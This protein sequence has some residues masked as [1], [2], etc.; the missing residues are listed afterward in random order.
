MISE[1]ALFLILPVN[2]GISYPVDDATLDPMSYHLY[3]GHGLC[4]PW[5]GATDGKTGVMALVETPNDAAVRI[6]RVDGLLCLAPEWQA[7]K[8]QFGPTR[9][10]R[11]AFFD[12]G[13]YVAMAKRY[14]HYAKDTGLFKT[15]LQKRAENA[16]VD[17][18]IG[19]VNVWCWDRKS[20]GNVPGAAIRR[21]QADSGLAAAAPEQIRR[22]NQLG[23]LTSRYDIYQDVMDPALFSSLRGLH[24]D[25]TTAAWPK[26]I[27][28]HA[29]GSWQ[30]GW[31]I[32]GK[33]GSWYPCGVLCDR[34]AVAYAR[35]R[36][37][38]ELRTHPYRC[39]FI[40]T[41]TAAPW[42]ECYSPDHPMTRSRAAASRWT[43]SS[44]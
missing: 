14:R 32:R 3:G 6:P 31:E 19:A 8:Q 37:P 9:R 13:G 35:E 18:L 20:C 15:F 36:I 42:N 2:E 22:M 41:T 4:M 29:D 25:W 7:E 12:Q 27:I 28:L 33:D 30:H 23:V 26:D 39:R 24:P 38:N 16:N 11:Y 34:H 5:W 40:D 21:H 1:K 10:L 44:S 17:L 43:C